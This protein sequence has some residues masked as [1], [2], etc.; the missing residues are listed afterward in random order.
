M[1]GLEL[2]ENE[3]ERLLSLVRTQN[4]LLKASG[5]WPEKKIDQS[6]E[7]KLIS[8]DVERLKRSPAYLEAKAEVENDVA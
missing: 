4:T 8:I 1:A 6:I 5:D 3:A 7:T 2:T